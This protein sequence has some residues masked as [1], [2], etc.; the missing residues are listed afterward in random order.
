MLSS[1]ELALRYTLGILFGLILPQALG[2]LGYY[3]TKNVN[4]IFKAATIFI[5]PVAFILI[6]ISFWSIV[7][8]RI[9][10]AGQSVCGGLAGVAFATILLGVFFHLGVGIMVFVVMQV[11]LKK[12]KTV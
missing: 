6:S 1:I 12:R 3:I 5:A 11:I 2:I 8:G 10:Q 4:K 9:N 7:A